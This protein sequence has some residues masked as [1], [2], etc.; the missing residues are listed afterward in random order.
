MSIVEADIKLTKQSLSDR[1]NGVEPLALAQSAVWEHQAGS[2]R[3]GGRQER[4][5]LTLIG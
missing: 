4:P 2:G 1:T 3:A 5:Y